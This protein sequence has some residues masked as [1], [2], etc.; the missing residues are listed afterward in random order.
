[1]RI[2]LEE[3][4]TRLTS[5]LQRRNDR[6]LV[7]FTLGSYYPLHRYPEGVRD[8]PNG[9]IQ[10]NDIVVSKF[11]DDTDRLYEL[12]EEAGGDFV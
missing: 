10:P 9:L 2:P 7:G 1:M 4:L 12:H 8:I 5:W 11:L 3:K 6:P